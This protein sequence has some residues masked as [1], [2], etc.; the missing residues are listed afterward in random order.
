MKSRVVLFM[1]VVTSI[2][3]VMILAIW[4]FS[5]FRGVVMEWTNETTSTHTTAFIGQGCIGVQKQYHATWVE[6][7]RYL[8]KSRVDPKQWATDFATVCAVRK[9]FPPDIQFLASVNENGETLFNYTVMPLWI[10]LALP[11]SWFSGF[12]LLKRLRRSLSQRSDSLNH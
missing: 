5:Y 1:H 7:F 9:Q 3:C 11:I 4:V 2:L 12:F 10:F 6:P 8:I